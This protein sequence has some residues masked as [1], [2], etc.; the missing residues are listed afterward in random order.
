MNRSDTALA[1]QS[2][3]LRNFSDRM[4]AGR[5]LI[6]DR[7][8]VMATEI[9]RSMARRGFAVDLL[10]EPGSPA[11]YSRFCA[12]YF[13]APPFASRAA[14]IQVLHETMC[15]GRYDAIFVCNEEVL[16]AI[17]SLPQSGL[18]P[19]LPL[20]PHR[21]VRIALSK[22]AMTRVACDAGVAVPRTL[23]PA[24][25]SEL[26]AV[27][28][29]LGFPVV[30]KGDRGESGERVRI[31]RSSGELLTSY[32]EILALE[33]T[34]GTLPAIQEY[35][36]GVAY[37]VGG[38]FNCGDPLRVCAHRKLVTFP[39]GGGLTVS[40]VT[41]HCPH[42]LA[43]AFRVFRAIGYTGLGHVEFIRDASGRFHFIEINPRVWGTIGV[44]EWAGVDF[45]TPY[46][47]LS[48]GGRPE[49]DLNFRAGIR[50]HRIARDARMVRARPSRLFGFVRDCFDPR[51]HSDFD[52]RDP[53]P[54]L[55]SLARR[56]LGLAR[57]N[58]SNPP[59]M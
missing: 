47:E 44:G 45:F 5:V 35:I 9:C 56:G 54:H 13:V 25:E 36:A 46:V 6:V 24:G 19:R 30:V 40:G 48:S 37:S 38:L 49:P 23:V 1:H 51:V 16:D 26:A 4:T 41:D 32:R 3:F 29:E 59:S 18:W 42:L 39:P 53:M 33:Q 27:A 31:A 12:G 57:S 20:P 2:R 17:I 15:N 14:F 7:R 52:W 10:G 50:F 21:T 8:A 22:V 11:F 58:E 28:R 34:S 43:E 55:V